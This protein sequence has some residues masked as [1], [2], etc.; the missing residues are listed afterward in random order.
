MTYIARVVI[1]KSLVLMDT[2][3]EEVL[4]FFKRQIWKLQSTIVQRWQSILLQ[5]E[6]MVGKTHVPDVKVK[7]FTPKGCCQK[8]MSFIRSVLLV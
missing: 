8:S 5:L 7:F 2:G 6:G 3:L 4:H 1:R